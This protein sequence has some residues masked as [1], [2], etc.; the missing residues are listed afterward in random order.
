MLYSHEGLEFDV[1]PNIN[2]AIQCILEKSYYTVNILTAFISIT[3]YDRNRNTLCNN[4]AKMFLELCRKYG[5]LQ[6]FND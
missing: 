6:Q 1:M 2:C 3:E 5:I 4:S